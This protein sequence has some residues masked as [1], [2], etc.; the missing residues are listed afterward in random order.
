[1]KVR[2]EFIDLIC[3]VGALLFFMPFFYAFTQ[4]ELNAFTA[5]LYFL[6]LYPTLSAL[7][8]GA[9]FVP[10]PMLAVE[11]MLKAANLKKGQRVYDIGCG[12]GRIVHE[13]T[14]R[15]GVKATGF[16]LSPF[17]YV[18]ARVRKLLWR[19]KAEIKFANFK[20]RDISDADAIFCY[21]LPE[22]LERLAPKLQAEL[23]DGAKLISYAFPVTSWKET[24]KIPRDAAKR[25]SPIWIYEKK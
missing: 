18:V 24:K 2:Q 13:A 17:V 3:I 11:K 10:T 21:L 7:V 12:D 15:Y 4:T 6:V 22:T 20:K 14:K 1:M 5:G 23:K 9:P 8:N 19:S 25:L 16:E